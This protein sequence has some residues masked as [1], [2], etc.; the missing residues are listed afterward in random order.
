MVV[1]KPLGEGE[2][3]ILHPSSF[4]AVHVEM[5]HQVGPGLA[6]DNDR[7][8]VILTNQLGNGV[9]FSPSTHPHARYPRVTIAD[10]VRAQRALLDAL[11]VR[12][13]DLIYGYSMGALQAFEWAVAYPD[14]VARVVAVCGA[15]RC[16]PLNR[17]FLNSLEA[18]LD[19]D[20]AG[21]VPGL[22]RRGLAAFATV[23][24]G[25]GVGADWYIGREYERRLRTSTILSRGATCRALRTATPTTSSLRCARGRRRT[26]RRTRAATLRRAAPRDGARDPHAVR[27]STGTLPRVRRRPRWR[28]C[29]TPSSGRS[30]RRL[31]IAPA[32]RG[33]PSRRRSARRSGARCTEF[34]SEDTL[35]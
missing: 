32:T 29:P 23:Y 24:A 9:S 16:G 2:R 35:A 10:N 13:L 11:G 18:I 20:G 4:D 1:G 6:L 19:A 3:V 5:E 14:A 21:G 27:A 7:H 33:G 17:V 8:T 25:W 28:S 26:W 31:A 22:P 30:S 15:A 12:E 34:W